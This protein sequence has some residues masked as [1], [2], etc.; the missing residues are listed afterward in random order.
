[1]DK[2]LILIWILLGSILIIENLVTWL[3]WYLFLSSSSSTWTLSGVSIV[4]WIMIWYWVRWLMVRKEGEE[5][6]YDF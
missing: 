6:D 3:R 5:D 1:M 4:I 2:A